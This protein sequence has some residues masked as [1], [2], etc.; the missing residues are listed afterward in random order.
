VAPLIRG[1]DVVGLLVVRR[2]TPG[3]FPPNT[4]DLIKTFA[5]QSVLAIQNARL[6]DN[7]E[8]RTREL[9][10]S[11]GIC[12]PHRTAWCRRKSSPHLAS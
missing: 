11:L 5:S 2:K 7:V 1:E 3:A 4:I 9:A 6:F 8:T 12:G 10:K